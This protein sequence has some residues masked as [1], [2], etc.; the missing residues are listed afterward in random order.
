MFAVFI[1]AALATSLFAV[2]EFAQRAN[3]RDAD[4]S[5]ALE[6]AES[7]LERGVSALYEASIVPD[8]D[9]LE[10]LEPTSGLGAWVIHDD[11]G[12]ANP[13]K[14]TLRSYKLDGLPVKPGLFDIYEVSSVS[15]PVGR[16]GFIRGAQTT[17][18]LPIS[19]TSLPGAIPGALYIADGH[20]VQLAG[21]YLIDGADHEASVMVDDGVIL[22]TDAKLENTYQSSSAGYVSSFW[23]ER[24]GVAEK[25]FDD[26]KSGGSI[27]SISDQVYQAGDKLNFFIETINTGDG[28]VYRHYAFG[29]GP[30]A[31]YYP[32]DGGDPKPYCRVEQ[33]DDVTYR[34]FFE[35]LPGDYADWDYGEEGDLTRQE[36]IASTGGDGPDQVVD[37]VILPE[38]SETTGGGQTPGM[39]RNSGI[40]AIGYDG[41]YDGLGISEGDDHVTTITEEGTNVTGIAAY[42][43]AYI[44]LEA[45][46]AE[47]KQNSDQV[48]TSLGGGANMTD[49]GGP[50]DY[51]VTYLDG[52]AGTLAGQR[53]GAGILVVNG[54]LHV[55]GQFKFEGL[56]VVLGDIQVTG[57]GDSGFSVLGAVM[58]NGNV[59]VTG[60]AD[61]LYSSEAITKALEAAGMTLEDLE[62]LLEPTKVMP[63]VYRV[64]RELNYIEAN[65]LGLI[66]EPVNE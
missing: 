3:E 61:I 44:P 4:W 31:M 55:S 48:I 2:V 43:Q 51:K 54:D 6:T 11:E 10:G 5:A 65:A 38:G 52:D 23:V 64:W 42:A 45:Y 24:D 34:L 28:T 36:C 59:Q 8:T 57:G 14:V 63:P 7:G 1:M 41:P 18:E 27:G 22:K 35:D 21:S 56:V 20:D 49:I 37:V 25:V 58:A 12:G 62:Q 26:S 39:A 9:Y 60:N 30:D 40:P 53:E 47:F 33:I 17:V 19:T 46:A 32:P 50:D 13:Y 16:N 15:S 66:D 29:T